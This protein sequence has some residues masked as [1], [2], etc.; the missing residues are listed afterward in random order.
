MG[1]STWLAAALAVSAFAADHLLDEVAP[2]LPHA[3]ALVLFVAALA[4]LAL[5]RMGRIWPVLL[6]RLPGPWLPLRS[7]RVRRWLAERPSV[8]ILVVQPQIEVGAG[9]A[10]RL[11]FSLTISRSFARVSEPTRML[12]AESK[13][14]LRQGQRRFVFRPQEAGG[15]LALPVHPGGSDA[16]VLTFL[17]PACPRALADAPD[18]HGEYTLEL[19]GVRAEIGE[20]SALTGVLPSARWAWAG[21]AA[22]SAAMLEAPELQSAF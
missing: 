11:S 16:V 15:F 14:V 7:W 5:D 18:F 4:V 10:N 6:M 22:W 13:L 19:R 3:V 2:K 8:S 17:D 20:D 9:I 1:K 21:S 12:F